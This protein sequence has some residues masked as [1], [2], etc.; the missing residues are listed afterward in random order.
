MVNWTRIL[1]RREFMVNSLLFLA[2]LG[3]SGWK[4]A[5]MMSDYRYLAYGSDT[6]R[7]LGKANRVRFVHDWPD[8]SPERIGL[9]WLAAAS[10]QLLRLPANDS[11]LIPLIIQVILGPLML[12]SWFRIMAGKT[13][14]ALTGAIL[15]KLLNPNELLNDSNF[16]AMVMIP[17]KLMLIY[18]LIKNWVKINRLIKLGL[19]GL[20]CLICQLTYPIA[21]L[22]L[23]GLVTSW[24]IFLAL[25][26]ERSRFLGASQ[27]LMTQA[28]AYFCF[29]LMMKLIFHQWLPLEIFFERI[30]LLRMYSDRSQW[31]LIGISLFYGLSFISPLIFSVLR[32]IPIVKSNWCKKSLV[33]GLYLINLVGWISFFA[34]LGLI[35]YSFWLYLYKTGFD[36]EQWQ[37]GLALLAT[38]VLFNPQKYR[39]RSSL[40]IWLNVVVV[41]SFWAAQISWPMPQVQF[42]LNEPRI[43]SLLA[44]LKVWFA[45]KAIVYYR[46]KLSLVLIILMLMVGVTGWLDYLVNAYPKPNNR[47]VIETMGW[48]NQQVEFT[49]VMFVA[50]YYAINELVPHEKFEALYYT[51]SSIPWNDQQRL[52]QCNPQMAQ[53]LEQ[54]LGYMTKN[55]VRYLIVRRIDKL[56]TKPLIEAWGHKLYGRE[57]AVYEKN[58]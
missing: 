55:K 54:L 29:Y 46:P 9:P 47:V 49:K 17:V 30:Y 42:L 25:R 31:L 41:S 10:A 53:C 26:Q 18:G 39:T 24:V 40:S 19:F 8:Y 20:F 1:S 28:L 57:I 33:P 44:Q 58:N 22:V 48:F 34:G 7:I 35:L 12:F 43:V 16:F 52:G 5:F 23:D 21:A 51:A 13:Q 38:A 11:L 36:R 27:I 2:L 56:A 6:L 32:Q 4:L 14:I 15:V 45:L 3:I 50:E 37:L